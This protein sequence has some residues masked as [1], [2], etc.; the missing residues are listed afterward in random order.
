MLP[1]IVI[2]ENALA[3]SDRTIKWFIG[4]C[5]G[6][7]HYQVSKSGEFTSPAIDD[8]RRGQTEVSKARALWSACGEGTCRGTWSTIKLLLE[9][10]RL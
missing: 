4:V 1:V 2:V 8:Q 10:V 3:T 5:G 6:P 7:L 9:D